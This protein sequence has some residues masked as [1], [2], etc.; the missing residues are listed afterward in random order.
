[1]TESEFSRALLKS[2]RDRGY[3]VQ[4]VE[5]GQITRGVPDVYVATK[6]GS[7]WV[8][9]KSIKYNPY[10]GMQVPWRAGQQGWMI[11]HYRATGIKCFTIV[12][13]P[14]RILAIPMVK[15]FP[16]NVV[17]LSDVI[18]FQSIKEVVL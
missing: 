16:R 6:Q 12:H 8:E 9:L 13:C 5:T 14:T 11:E 10:D 7:T 3:F 2:W 1:M 15:R 18:V 4:R 17:M